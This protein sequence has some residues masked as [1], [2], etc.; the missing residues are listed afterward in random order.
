MKTKNYITKAFAILL[1]VSSSWSVQAQCNH[2]PTITNPNLVQFEQPT[3][4]LCGPQETAVL[5]TQVYDSYQWYRKDYV[6]APDVPEWVAIAGAT[7]QTLTIVST[8][9]TLDFAEPK[10]L[11][12]KFVNQIALAS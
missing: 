5:S 10:N 1:L 7:S 3:I 8:K 12:F 11:F 4:M 9:L 2:N 6:F